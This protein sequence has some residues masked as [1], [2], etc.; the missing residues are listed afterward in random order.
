MSTLLINF[1]VPMN[2]AR[3]KVLR[4]ALPGVEM[5][6]CKEPGPTPDELAR[7][8]F[9]LGN[10]IPASLKQCRKLR[11]LQLRSAGADEYVNGEVPKGVTLATSG[12]SLAHSVSEHMLGMLLA[13][14]KH[15][16]IYSRN[17]TDGIW[18]D[19]GPARTIVDSTTLIVGLGSLG[20]EFAWRMKA[21]GSHVIGVRRAGTDKPDSVDELY[22]GEKLDQVLPR[23]DF[24]ALFLPGTSAARNII[25]RRRLSLM[26][27]D[28]YILNAGRGIAIDQEALCDLMDAG[29]FAGAGLDVTVPEPLPSTHRLWKTPRVLICPH[30]AGTNHLAVTGDYIVK[31]AAQ[32]IA[33]FIAGG[34]LTSEIDLATG[35][36]KLPKKLP[37]PLSLR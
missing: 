22:L 26:K 6:Y 11:F 13:M 14:M 9:I 5:I 16:D 2:E 19:A 18:K 4:D 30:I 21:L 27:D 28:S 8:D 36:R 10:P 23:A 15:L 25:D 1:H 35:Y 17:M 33:S 12:G 34:E 7:A 29:K 32:N 20:T 24:L 31:I 3:W 37:R